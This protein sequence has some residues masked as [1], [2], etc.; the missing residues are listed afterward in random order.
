MLN[1]R[2][3]TTRVQ[4]FMLCTEVMRSLIAKECFS[5]VMTEKEELA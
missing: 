3:V 1:T 5:R 4:L 2:G